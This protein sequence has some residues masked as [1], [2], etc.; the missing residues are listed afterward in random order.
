MQIPV[1]SCVLSGVI[2]F[3]LKRWEMLVF[4]KNK[5]T[6]GHTA[7]FASTQTVRKVKSVHRA[8]AILHLHKNATK[9]Y[10]ILD[11]QY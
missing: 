8:A 10:F 5:D 1:S 11:N 4:D 6:K 3:S 7:Q 9:K 2:L